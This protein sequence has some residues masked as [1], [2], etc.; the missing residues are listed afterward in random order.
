M[1]KKISDMISH[2]FKFPEIIIQHERKGAYRTV[3]TYLSLLSGNPVARRKY[4]L[5]IVK[6]FNTPVFFYKPFIIPNKRS[7]QSIKKYY[8]T[9]DYKCCYEKYFLFSRYNFHFEPLYFFTKSMNL[10]YIL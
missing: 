1:N 9:D 4:M 5:H 7:I 10:G 8:Y 3:L 6:A 2:G